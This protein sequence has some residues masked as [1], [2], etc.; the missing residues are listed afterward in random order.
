MAQ[1]HGCVVAM[2]AGDA[3]VVECAYVASSL[4]DLPFFASPLR[5]GPSGIQEVLPLPPMNAAERQNFEAMRGELAAS[6]QKA[7]GG[8]TARRGMQQTQE[9]AG[10]PACLACRAAHTACM[11][12][13]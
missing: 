2:T 4:T 13:C 8:D 12:A 10:L 7:S 5:L 6:I 11:H 9:C 1:Q 3:G